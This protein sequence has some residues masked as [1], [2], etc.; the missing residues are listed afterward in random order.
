MLVLQ[1]ISIATQKP[2]AVLL[3]H[4]DV[5]KPLL[6][7]ANVCPKYMSICHYLENLPCIL[8]RQQ[9]QMKQLLKILYHFS[10]MYI[11]MFLSK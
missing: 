11:D 2:D 5:Y 9:W 8:V 6:R 10:L 1:L 4:R 3:N 7:N